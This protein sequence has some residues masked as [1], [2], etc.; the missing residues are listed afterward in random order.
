MIVKKIRD[1]FDNLK[2]DL[3]NRLGI[4]IP[5]KVFETHFM[6]TFDFLKQTQ[7]ERY[8]SIKVKISENFT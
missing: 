1:N 6:N 3:E 5:Q 7:K 8:V 2:Q 4:S